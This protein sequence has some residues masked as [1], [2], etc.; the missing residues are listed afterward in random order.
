MWCIVKKP[1]EV[2][3]HHGR[4]EGEATIIWERN[5]TGPQKIEF[6]RETVRDSLYEIVGWGY[7][8]DDNPNLA[9]RFWFLGTYRRK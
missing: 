4:T 5:E 1:D 6:F 9:P 2:I 3:V 7:Y 8:G